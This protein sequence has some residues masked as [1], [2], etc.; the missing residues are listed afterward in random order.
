MQRILLGDKSPNVVFE[1]TSAQPL[2]GDRPQ[3]LLATAPAGS[4]Y[5]SQ[6]SDIRPG[7]GLA[8]ASVVSA[9]QQVVNCAEKINVQSI[10]VA[11]IGLK[12]GIGRI[13]E[14]LSC[15]AAVFVPAAFRTLD[16]SDK[17]PVTNLMADLQPCLEAPLPDSGVERSLE[18][19][20]PERKEGGTVELPVVNERKVVERPQEI[21]QEHVQE[22]VP[23]VIPKKS[24]E[25]TPERIAEKIP[26]RSAEK[27]P[28][29]VKEKTPEKVQEKMPEKIP[30]KVQETV[31][32]R[33]PEMVQEKAQV[34]VLEKVQ[35][36]VQER[37]QEDLQEKAQEKIPDK[38]QKKVQE[39]AQE[40][41]QEKAQEKVQEK[42]QEKVQEK[43][44]DK[45]QEKV[46]EKSA[47]KA[48]ERPQGLIP[49]AKL[50]QVEREEI[51]RPPTVAKKLEVEPDKSEGALSSVVRFELKAEKAEVTLIM[52]AERL[53]EDVSTDLPPSDI[54]NHRTDLPSK[55]YSVSSKHL[56]LSPLR[57][58]F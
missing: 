37:V 10:P 40:K 32:E 4:A 15:E 42:A 17:K 43:A 52:A 1:S 55:L 49:V 16:A 31:S 27:L 54:I 25:K 14:S 21:V 29:K 26:E 3:V 19:P 47:E 8:L 28:E 50:P 2:H 46:Q 51:L 34:K 33:I 58:K 45:V 48:Q 30:E 22:I 44:Q 5:E 53:K 39:K 6:K 20:S 9:V 23:E 57:L 13:D 41:V 38:A 24:A 12:G 11:D 56:F 7:E 36:K 18:E 35:E